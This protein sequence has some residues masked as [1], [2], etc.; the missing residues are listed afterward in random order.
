MA[1]PASNVHEQSERSEQIYRSQIVDLVSPSRMP[2]TVSTAVP[3]R[4][5]GAAAAQF[6]RVRRRAV[7]AS[8]RVLANRSAKTGQ[9]DLTG[10][11][12]L[13]SFWVVGMVT[14]ASQ[15]VS[16]HARP[17]P[18]SIAED[19]KPNLSQVQ[20]IDQALAIMPAYIARQPGTRDEKIT[21]G[22]D[23]FVRDRFFHGT[24]LLSAKE[25]W[26]A[27]LAGLAWS[28]LAIPVLPN[29]ILKH[30]R[31]M[32]SQQAIVFM[33]LLK[34]FKIDY[35][36]VRFGGPRTNSGHF[37]TAAK[38]DGAWQY[39]DPD[40]EANLRMPLSTVM[41]GQRL[42]EIYAQPEMVT[43]IRH[44]A[45]SGSASFSQVNTFPAPRGGP[46]QSVT[47][48]LSAYGWLILGVVW[49]LWRKNYRS[50]DSLTPQ[51][52]ATSAEWLPAAEP[53][54]R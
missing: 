8:V 54:A 23:Q 11:L 36:S 46:F 21:A 5:V 48:W 17:V 39:F 13:C 16:V 20:N 18:S 35:G 52:K 53:N 27:A 26:I 12:L 44:A 34:H 1:V 31:A 38:V 37:A 51:A 25:N 42:K 22:I 32:C 50:L 15:T 6:S 41:D 30:R 47:G 10:Y 29:D 43:L 19:W 33:E 4:L 7:I 40:Q 49:L 24:S 45:A 2:A 3:S 9:G 14:L 28:N